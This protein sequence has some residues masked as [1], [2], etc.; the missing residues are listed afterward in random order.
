MASG[1]EVHPGSAVQAPV[2]TT[3]SDLKEDKGGAVRHTKKVRAVDNSNG[4]S[5][6]EDRQTKKMRTTEDSKEDSDGQDRQ[7]TNTQAA[8][9]T[10][11]GCIAV[12]G[13]VIAAVPATVCAETGLGGQHESSAPK[14]ATAVPNSLDDV[15]ETGCV[16]EAA[17][18]SFYG[19]L[20]AALLAAGFEAGT[21]FVCVDADAGAGASAGTD[22]GAADSGV[23]LTA[24]AGMGVR[25]EEDGA[26]GG[27]SA[28]GLHTLRNFTP[29]KVS[30][31]SES[32]DLIR[33]LPPA[34]DK[35]VRVKERNE[36]QGALVFENGDRCV[37]TAPPVYEEL[38]DCPVKQWVVVSELAAKSLVKDPEAKYVFSPHTG[39]AYV[40]RGTGG[41]IEGVSAL[42]C[43][44]GK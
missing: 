32:R 36:V 18:E 38:Q 34:A 25:F 33:T 1:V 8:N 20:D 40:V 2:V 41:S 3:P 16:V 24:G 23:V 28:G 37:V 43:W 17:A 30:L 35:P 19:E 9:E 21:Q 14:A 31:Y 5:E 13:G 10:V 7:T 29:H 11:P 15:E 4:D 12:A 26:E 42:I 27:A 39:P 6:G 22:K 44:K